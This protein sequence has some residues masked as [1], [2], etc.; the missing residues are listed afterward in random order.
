MDIAK[1]TALIQDY[2][3]QLFLGQDPHHEHS[4]VWEC[5]DNPGLDKPAGTV[6]LDR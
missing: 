1:S 4:Q 3:T 5:H 6:R 2:L